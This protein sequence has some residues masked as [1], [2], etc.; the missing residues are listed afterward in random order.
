MYC[1]FR[2]KREKAM[3]VERL[4]ANG[5]TAGDAH[6]MRIARQETDVLGLIVSTR[7]GREP[8][9]ESRIS[10]VMARATALGKESTDLSI[11]EATHRDMIATGRHNRAL[12][13]ELFDDQPAG[14]TADI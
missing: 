5:L 8:H 3:N 13:A 6:L 14:A 1:M 7:H 9:T 10:T 12:A 4:K 2:I 11:P